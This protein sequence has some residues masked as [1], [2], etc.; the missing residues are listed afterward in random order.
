MRS[1]QRCRFTFPWSDLVR[2]TVPVLAAQAVLLWCGPFA[3]CTGCYFFGGALVL[4]AQVYSQRDE[5]SGPSHSFGHVFFSLESQF[6][7]VEALFI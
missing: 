2:P 4:A 5:L 1:R 7:L 6:F 3:G